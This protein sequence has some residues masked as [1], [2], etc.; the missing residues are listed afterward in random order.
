MLNEALD[1]D[2]D[3]LEALVTHRVPVNDGLADHP[4]IQVGDEPPVLGPLGLLN[5][6]FGVDEAGW[7][8]IAANV[9][10]GNIMAFVV[11]P[12]GRKAM[13]EPVTAE[14]VAQL[15]NEALDLDAE[16]INALFNHRVPVNTGFTHH[17]TIQVLQFTGQ[18]PTLGVLGLLNGMFGVDETG[19]GFIQAYVDEFG[20]IARFLGPSPKGEG[21]GQRALRQSPRRAG[22]CGSSPSR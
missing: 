13:R 20:R 9:E 3:A 17:P 7:G 15:L 4:T 10:L 5:G 12:T 2:G 16:G 18:P 1:L 11:R 22:S 19:W 21:D 6:M 14:Q 8:F